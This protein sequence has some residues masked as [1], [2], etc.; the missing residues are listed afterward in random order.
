MST[1]DL[2]QFAEFA[3]SFTPGDGEAFRKLVKDATTLFACLQEDLAEE[4]GVNPS[5]VSRWITG[6]ALPHSITQQ[7]LAQRF[8]DKANVMIKERAVAAAERPK[9]DRQPSQSG[10]DGGGAVEGGMFM[11]GKD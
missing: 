8:R 10:G 6:K 5:S 1:N 11:K 9:H 2:V 4:L 3:Q 7:T